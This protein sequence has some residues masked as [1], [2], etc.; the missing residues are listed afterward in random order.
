MGKTINFN[1]KL[2][3]KGYWWLPNNP[4][5]TIAGVLTYIPNEKILLELIGTFD[6]KKDFIDTFFSSKSEDIIHGL[7]SNSE[8]ITL[9]NCHP[10]GSL[11]FG[12]PF[13]I[14][15]MDGFNI[16]RSYMNHIRPHNTI[17]N[18]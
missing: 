8:E 3:C 16:F 13:P 4:N 11:N 5:E 1:E 9:V 15:F 14:K 7:T 2:E 12:C 18:I 6:S 17:N 10:S